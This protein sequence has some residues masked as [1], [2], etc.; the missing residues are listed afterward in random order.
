V[1]SG[2]PGAQRIDWPDVA[3][4]PSLERPQGFIDLVLEWTA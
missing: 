3:H 2:V 4:L 1:V